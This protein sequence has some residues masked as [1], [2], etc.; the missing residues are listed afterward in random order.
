MKALPRGT[1]RDARLQTIDGTVPRLTEKKPG[2]R[3]ANR[4]PMA[5]EICGNQDPVVRSVSATHTYR[6][7]F[8]EEGV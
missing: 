8:A 1:K 4:C 6:C 7:H 2:C 3:F 5:R